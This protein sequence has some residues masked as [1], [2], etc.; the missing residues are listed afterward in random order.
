MRD[1]FL[2]DI[3]YS[4]RTLAHSPGFACVAILTLAVAIA[5][6]TTV[7]S[8]VDAVMLK[9]VPGVT[10]GRLALSLE[11]IRPDGQNVSYPDYLDFR[12]NLKLLDGLA[13]SQE[14]AAFDIGEGSMPRRIWGELVSGNYFAVL[15]VRPVK[16][17]TFNLDERGERDLVAVISHRF[18]QDYFRG[19][20]G[21]VGK[22]LRANRHDLTIIGVAPP[23]FGGAWRGVSFD[24]WVPLTMGTQLNQT[25]TDILEWRGARGILTVARLKP[26]VTLEQARAEV[27][28]MAA[29][30]A[31]RYPQTNDKIGATLNTE[32]EAHNNV[33]FLLAAP[34]RILLAMCAV[35]LLIACANVANL[36]LARATARQRELSLRLA[37]GA[38]RARLSRQLLT[39]ALLLAGLG[40]L[41]GIPLA[42]W[43]RHL[44]LLLVPATEYPLN[45]NVPFNVS[46][47]AFS[48][49]TCVV[50][51][52]VSGL[53]PS[54]HAV[55]SDLVDALK[56]GGRSG[57]SGAGT[58]R[59][60][61]ALVIGEV[62]LAL[63]ALVGAGLFA[64]SF[65]A[66][67]SINPGFDPKNMLV[68]KF[69]L[70][71][72]GY[73]AAEQRMEFVRRLR[74]R[75]ESSPGIIQA[76]YAE[77]IP[78]GFSGAPGCDV[79]VDGYIRP[80]GENPAI[81]RNLVS[82]GYFH[83]LKIPILK[84]HDFG[85]QDDL[86]SAPV[87]I[88]NEAFVRHFLGNRDPI[89][90]KMRGCGAQVTVIGLAKDSKYYSFVENVRPTIYVPF[91][92]RYG[93]VGDYDRGIGLYIRAAGEP[94]QALPVLRHA[95]SSIDPGVGV[96]DAMPFEDYMGASVFPQR[97]AASLL[98]V[99]GA[100]ALLLAS[101]GLYS[102]MAYSVT[103]RT[104]EIGIRM[105]LGGQ[106]S[107]VMSLI[108]RKG[109]ALTLIGLAA[110][111][112]A[113]LSI[114][115]VVASM[116]L[117]VSAT[118]PWTF[119]CASTFLAA[120]ALLASLFPARRATQ[121]D[122]LVALHH[123]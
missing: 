81:D 104:H 19:D 48:V 33:R 54:L 27:R 45:L 119:L 44:L 29:L 49:L 28:S 20:P 107:R 74:E 99:L 42:L 101:V 39:E 72:S 35:V 5:A 22:T 114:S 102:V 115:Q 2:K 11:S 70:S 3:R 94:A 47:L 92:Q 79:E 40:A 105:A 89:G 1:G 34:L 77:S 98:S 55:R 9:P 53:V 38:N 16:G 121:V 17:R 103:Q 86:K 109:L 21:I 85:V 25:S 57:T 36:L 63:M 41:V 10:D 88:V 106:R 31:R 71:P 6:N 123:E 76:G 32:E 58:H 120:V 24:I 15:G 108:L 13:A 118:D 18:W 80:R 52:A 37:L 50:A 46:I 93:S 110:G 23:D 91:D 100:I 83:L 51:A 122:P 73:T 65:R 7:F 112:V 8:W 111:L 67:S 61:D 90:M 96:Y 43:A 66:A 69:Y 113:A 62:A 12:A 26:G 30:L 97:V 78:L 87:A 56:E 117:N 60:R 14:P 59:M 68:S 95:V 64:K 4:L 116:L 84:G 75:L 82:P